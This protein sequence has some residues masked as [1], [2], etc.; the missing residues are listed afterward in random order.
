MII[1]ILNDYVAG[2]LLEKYADKLPIVRKYLESDSSI[3]DLIT[4]EILP[5]SLE[6]FLADHPS[7]R[8]DEELTEAVIIPALV[9]VIH[10]SVFNYELQDSSEL[11]AQLNELLK[12][13]T[14]AS[15]QRT[16]TKLITDYSKYFYAELTKHQSPDAILIKNYLAQ[17]ENKFLE[18]LGLLLSTTDT[19]ENG[20]KA[21]TDETIFVSY[22]RTNLDFATDLEYKLKAMGFSIKR[23]RVDLKGGQSW[24]EQLKAMIQEARYIVLCLSPES[25][26]S[27]YVADEWQYAR[28]VGTQVIPVVAEDIDFE[29][30]DYTVPKWMSD[31]HWI[32]FRELA[33]DAERDTE[34]EIQWAA[35]INQLNSF[36]DSSKVPFMV[37]EELAEDY[38]RRDAPLEALVNNLVDETRSAVAITT[39]LRG[40]GGFGKTTLARAL[41]FD[42]RVRG[43]FHDGI[44]W[45]T[46]GEHITE[47]EIVARILELV[48]AII[49]AKPNLTTI[50][51]ATNEL[52]KALS[53]KSMLIVI[54]DVW[55]ERHLKPFLQGGENCSR[56]ITTRDSN[57]L[58]DESQELTVDEMTLSE[59]VQLLRHKVGADKDE[60]FEALAERLGQ[61]ALLLKLANGALQDY[62]DTDCTVAEAITYVNEDLD[63]EGFTALDDPDNPDSR[64]KAVNATLQASLKKLKQQER[65]AFSKLAIFPDDTSIPLP[66]L[67]KCWNLR[68]RKARMLAKRLLD[69]SLVLRFETVGQDVHPSLRLHD[70]VRKYLIEQN[71]DALKQ[72]HRDFLDSYEVEQWYKLPEDELYLWMNLTYHL[73]GADRQIDLHRLLTCSPEWMNAKYRVTLGNNGYVADLEAAMSCYEDPLTDEQQIIEVTQLYTARQVVHTQVSNLSDEMLATMALVGREQEARNFA[74]LRDTPEGVFNAIFAIEKALG[75]LSQHSVI[76]ALTKRAKVIQD[77]SKK[78]S[79]LGLISR[80]A[81]HLD[82]Q[83]ALSVAQ[84]IDD[85][86]HKTSALSTI[87]HQFAKIDPQQVLDVTNMIEYDRRKIEIL[88]KIANDMIPID[89]QL[90]VIIANNIKDFS[91]QTEV[92]GKITSDVAKR[93]HQLAQFIANNIE[94]IRQK[95]KVQRLI[96]REIAKTDTQLALTITDSIKDGTEKAYALKD[97]TSEIAKSNPQQALSIAN[98]I[99][100]GYA[101]DAALEEII[102]EI[103]KSNPQQALSIANNIQRGYAKDRALGKITSEIAKSNPQQALSITNNIEDVRQKAKVLSQIASETTKTNTQLAQEVFA[104]VFIIV[105]DFESTR[106][107][108]EVLSAIASE[109]AK[110]DIQQALSITNNIEDNRQKAKV[111]SQIASETAKTDIQQA[112]SITLNI[113]STRE[114]AE[115]LSQIANEL[116]TSDP[117]SALTIAN[118]IEE[119]FTK[120][121]ILRRIIRKAA[122]INTQQAQSVLNNAQIIAN[123]IED[124]RQKA[125]I[126]ISIANVAA[127]TDI[128]LSQ[129]I[130]AEAQIT[131]N[132]V[133]STRKVYILGDIAREVAKTNTQKALNIANNIED[134][135]YKA[136]VLSQ[137]AN[138]TSKT[139]IQLA[140]AIFLDAQAIINKTQSR[141]GSY[142]LSE[143]AGIAA[144]TDIQL[145][146]NIA[147]NIEDTMYKARALGRITLIVANADISLALSIA[148]NIEDNRQKAE[149]LSEVAGIVANI[150]IS[151]ALSIANNIEDAYQQSKG[152]S[153]IA[154]VATKTDIQLALN[155]ANNIEDAYQ[156]AWVLVDIAS[157]AINTDTQLSHTLFT[158]AQSITNSIRYT[159]SK[160]KLLRYIAHQIAELDIQLALNIANSIEDAYQKAWALGDIASVVINT[161]T[162]LGLSISNSIED[163]THKAEVQGDLAQ[164]AANFDIQLALSIITAI[165]DTS[166]KAESLSAIANKATRTDYQLGLSIANSI[167]DSQKKAS[168]L[169]D[170]AEQ[171]I[172]KKSTVKGF[173]T[174]GQRKLEDYLQF[175]VSIQKTDDQTLP[176]IDQSLWNQMMLE[177]LTIICWVRPSWEAVRDVFEELVNEEAV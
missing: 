148:N 121:Y 95:A 81:S 18:K 60:A 52:R 39:A 169:Y 150:D 149:I 152:L 163:A 34:P 5:N 175:L 74:L 120:E 98:N 128:Q 126:L 124:N 85:T 16:L 49:G 115:I 155:I 2:K 164:E 170:I 168:A 22:S 176:S 47:N 105:N 123:N 131:A 136:E 20:L 62:V 83:F 86:Y 112:L 68:E 38:V 50:E 94:D 26:S 127:K 158:D 104:A 116:T 64:T 9:A 132:N 174:L 15:Q 19:K 80:V 139:D 56:L 61:W 102:S 13:D 35:F 69:K 72:W 3:S 101:K 51:S 21:A 30:D 14:T 75:R 63:S 73:Q 6:Q 107:K 65:E 55:N 162:E 11:Q 147:N 31:Q 161:N 10:Q 70:V 36:P 106:E 114:K 117:Q 135:M 165:E 142:L 154:G 84:N 99:Q 82:I 53:D 138:E 66:T 40:T 57:T 32:D 140:E 93:D 130:F 67:A 177:A 171:M 133:K 144:K 77:A 78:A 103:A 100:N 156:K 17:F 24:W 41:C 46:L 111:L 125:N 37:D 110:T 97:I 153:K 137:I 59:S 113:E 119:T 146:L 48:Y 157:I 141:R 27:K 159:K 143:I 167:Q 129:K 145:A 25:I 33:A 28:Q 89:Y 108:G 122:K 166:S 134:T 23:D 7:I 87:A 118:S 8:Q 88:S 173:D 54:D 76:L 58:P 4:T 29:S 44:L 43:A 91:K 92:L 96:A 90:A 45:V 1:Q 160:E 151:L 109:I 42:N 79:A 71:R 12:I 172:I